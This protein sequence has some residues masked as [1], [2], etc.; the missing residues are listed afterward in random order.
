MLDIKWIR[1]NPEKFDSAMKARN[2]KCESARYLIL[3]DDLRKIDE[4]IEQEK[5]ALKKMTQKMHFLLIKAS[6]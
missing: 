4:R 1:E 3:L 6:K 2:I 5:N